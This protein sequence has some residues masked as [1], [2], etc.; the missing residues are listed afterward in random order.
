[1]SDNPDVGSRWSRYRIPRLSSLFFGKA[2]QWYME[3]MFWIEQDT[4]AEYQGWI[5]KNYGGRVH[6]A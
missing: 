6:T 2:A 5:V 4:S 3:N 1:M